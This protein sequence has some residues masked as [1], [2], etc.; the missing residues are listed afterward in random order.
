[1]SAICFGELFEQVVF[2]PNWLVGDVDKNIKHFHLFKHFTDPGMFYFPASLIS[3][4]AHLKLLG[5]ASRLTLEQKGKVRAS[6]L[7]FLVV[8]AATVFVIVWINVPAFDRFLL[9]GDELRFRITLWAAI[10][11]I[12]VLLP[13]LGMLKLLSLL[14]LQ[15]EGQSDQDPGPPVAA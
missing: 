7:L 15:Q 1:M 14:S 11:V 3:L 5:K 4:I 9:R 8:L 6:L 10:N 12:R 2:V 13:F